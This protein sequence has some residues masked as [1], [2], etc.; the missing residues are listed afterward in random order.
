MTSLVPLLDVADVA[1]AR[2]EGV[3]DDEVRRSIA[4]VARRVRRRTGFLGEYLVVALAGG[5]GTGKSSLL[6]A[7]VSGNVVEVG[8][9]RPTT[10]DA[11]AV[12]PAQGDADLSGLRRDL[13]IDKVVVSDAVTSTVFVDLPDFD[14]IQAA[15]RHIVERVLPAVDAVI[16]VFD[17][18]KYADPVV[19]REFLQ[20]LST[21]RDQFIFVLNQ[22]D[23]LGPD[24][25]M[26]AADLEVLLDGDGYGDPEV[27][28]TVA[29]GLIDVADLEEALDRRFDLKTTALAKAALDLREVAN[30][31]WAACAERA[32]TTTDDDEAQ[33][34][35]LAAATFV[36]LGVEAYDFH[37]SIE[38]DHRG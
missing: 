15:H 9:V 38:G 6:N 17:P 37:H 3:L 11:V 14:S 31:S 36:S 19:H 22:V 1:V 30:D 21:Y 25:S 28:S 5:T 7:L 26:V 32:K 27:V 13:C 10:S 29:S 4:E 24:A 23:R 34:V 33:D 12:V 18:E 20:R 16:W 2:T 35:A 8:I